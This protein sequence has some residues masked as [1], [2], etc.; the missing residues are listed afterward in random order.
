MVAT[1]TTYK[2]IMSK[3]NIVNARWGH[4]CEDKDNFGH[5]Y[6]KTIAPD[7]ALFFNSKIDIFLLHENIYCGYSVEV[8]QYPQHMFSWRNKENINLILSLNR[9]L[10]LVIFVPKHIAWPLNKWWEILNFVAAEGLLDLTLLLLNTTCSACLSKQCSSR[11]VGFWRS[12][13]IW[14]CTVCH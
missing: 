5:F 8:P 9:A 1:A 14:I 3:T 6:T 7:K 12:Q 4:K 11:S 2:L 10:I 13:L